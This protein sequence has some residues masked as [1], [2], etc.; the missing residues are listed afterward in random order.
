MG[1]SSICVTPDVVGQII[2]V[3]SQ[4]LLLA[5]FPSLKVNYQWKGMWCGVA[6]VFLDV[7]FDKYDELLCHFL[8]LHRK[9]CVCQSY[10]SNTNDAKLPLKQ[11]PVTK[12]E[13]KH[14]ALLVVHKR[15]LYS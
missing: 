10:P 9:Q 6:K 1:R 2:C 15:V 11:P 14:T 13:L 8:F 3:R 5:E 4:V 7:I 12:N